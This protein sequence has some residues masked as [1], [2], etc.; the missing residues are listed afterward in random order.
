VGRQTL[1][2]KRGETTT[3]APLIAKDKVIVGF[4]GD[5]CA[6]RGRLESYDLNTGKLVWGFQSNGADKDIG[7]ISESKRRIPDMA[8]PTRT[9]TDGARFKTTRARRC[10][11]RQGIARLG[12]PGFAETTEVKFRRHNQQ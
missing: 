10:A 11:H 7:L 4:G 12:G 8:C 2:P 3:S 9:A 5:E 1:V 6:A